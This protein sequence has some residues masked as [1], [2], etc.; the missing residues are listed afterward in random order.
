MGWDLASLKLMVVLREPVSREFSLYNHKKREVRKITQFSCVGA[1]SLINNTNRFRFA[2]N[3]SKFL[4]THDEHSWFSD[5]AVNGTVMSFESFASTVLKRRISTKWRIVSKYVD[6]LKRWVELFGR[7]QLL[8]LSY[9]ELQDNPNATQKRIESFLGKELPGKLPRLNTKTG[10]G[11]S[12]SLRN[13]NQ[14]LGPIFDKK[15][16]ELYDLLEKYPGPSMEQRPFPRFA[17]LESVSFLGTQ[18][19]GQQPTLNTE[20]ANNNAS[21]VAIQKLRPTI[22]EKK[23]QEQQFSQIETSALEYKTPKVLW[24]YW[25]QGL[26]HLKSIGNSSKYA[27]DFQCI[28]AMISLNPSWNIRLLD[29]ASILDDGNLA[30]IYSSIVSNDKLVFDNG[31]ARISRPLASDLLRV[32]LL[33][34]YGGVWTDTSVCPFMELDGF[35]PNLVGQDRNGLYAPFVGTGLHHASRD[36]LFS[37]SYDLANCHLKRNSTYNAANSRSLE[38][39]FMAANTPHNPLI[40]EWLNVLHTHLLDLSLK[41]FPYFLA[42]CSLTQARMK[43]NVAEEVFTS[44]VG[45]MKRSQRKYREDNFFPMCFDAQS[46]D[47]DI[48]WYLGHCAALKKQ[49]TDSVRSFI[50]SSRY[51]EHLSKATNNFY[52]FSPDAHGLHKLE[53]IH[54]PKTGGTSIELAGESYHKYISESDRFE[55]TSLTSSNL[56]F[57]LS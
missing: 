7:Q 24:M 57:S 18:L 22:F 55:K 31:K 28:E 40:D 6:F 30:P 16:Q 35:V 32:E 23:N 2:L 41:S 12:A 48:D 9:D 34:R 42:H 27:T 36:E 33:S 47:K 4:E 46:D 11:G 54:I 26:Q 19:A 44:N 17:T 43:S 49:K 3:I 20:T 29:K 50:L 1:P 25:E 51:F 5:V 45:R 39:F 8:V 56:Q 13:A 15:N 21:L 53:F 38:T 37:S 52:P 14:I 10:N